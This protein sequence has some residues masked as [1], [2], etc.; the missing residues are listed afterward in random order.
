MFEGPANQVHHHKGANNSKKSKGSLLSFWRLWWIKV[1]EIVNLVEESAGD[2]KSCKSYNYS[3]EH[4]LHT[5][6]T[7]EDYNSKEYHRCSC[8]S[9]DLSEVIIN[10]TWSVFERHIHVAWV[11]INDTLLRVSGLFHT[12]RWT[13]SIWITKDIDGER[14]LFG[15]IIWACGTSCS[16]NPNTSLIRCRIWGISP[17]SVHNDFCCWF[18]RSQLEALTRAF[19]LHCKTFWVIHTTSSFVDEHA[20]I[21]CD[22]TCI[23]IS[24]K[25]FQA[26]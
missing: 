11:T 17:A 5:Q 6:S 16:H 1:S 24:I 14:H 20:E 25:V 22:V 12:L 4:F 7:N 8:H 10:A 15:R 3:Q 13:L 2:Y 19:L 23:P 26:L 18:I 9:Q 21:K